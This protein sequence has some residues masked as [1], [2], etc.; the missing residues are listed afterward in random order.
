MCDIILDLC[1]KDSEKCNIFV[2]I[3][4]I[5]MYNRDNYTKYRDNY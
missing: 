1:Y 5:Y 4:N 3:R 2:I